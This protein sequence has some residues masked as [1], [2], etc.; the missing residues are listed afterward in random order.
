M[1]RKGYSKNTKTYKYLGADYETVYIHLAKSFIDNYGRKPTQ[2][3]DINIDHI[4]P[5][6]LAKNE[7]EMIELQHYTNLQWL[8]AEDNRNK[9]D[10]YE[11]D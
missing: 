2:E 9:G 1:K 4:K 5:C 8:L 10:K 11:E 3:D 7:Q 6:A